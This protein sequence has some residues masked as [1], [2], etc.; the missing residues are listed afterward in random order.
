MGAL[1]NL[2]NSQ[3]TPQTPSS[4]SDLHGLLNCARAVLAQYVDRV[5]DVAR[6]AHWIAAKSDPNAWETVGLQF[7]AA[8]GVDG[9][10]TL[11]AIMAHLEGLIAREQAQDR[12]P[13]LRLGKM[14]RTP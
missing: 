12:P 3:T 1:K 7:P 10:G 8:P 5:P 13:D 11:T 14:R 4:F 6:Q 2:M 9:A